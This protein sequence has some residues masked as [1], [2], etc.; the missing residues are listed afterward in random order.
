MTPD[1]PDPMPP[2][3]GVSESLGANDGCSAKR[4]T[5]AELQA[6]VEEI[7]TGKREHEE[8]IAREKR[9][10]ELLEKILAKL[11]EK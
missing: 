3:L 7:A 9:V 8:R 5:L 1:T 4:A 2:S 10:V 11:S 6:E